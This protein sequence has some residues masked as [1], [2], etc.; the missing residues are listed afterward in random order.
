MELATLIPAVLCILVISRSGTTAAFRK[1]FLPVLLLMPTYFSWSMRPLPSINFLE[2]ATFPLGIAMFAMD[3]PRWKFT[4][5]DLWVAIWI[6]SCSY[7]DYQRGLTTNAIFQLFATLSSGLFPY[8]AGK[9]LIEQTGNRVKVCTMYVLLIS[10]SSFVSAYEFFLRRNPYNYIFSHFYPGQWAVWITQIRWG[11]GRVA[12]PFSQSELA[13]MMVFTALLFALW[14][15]RYNSVEKATYPRPQVLM[16]HGTRHIWILLAATY[17]TQARGPW[18]GGIMA[19]IFAGIGRAKFPLRRAILVVGT[20]VLIGLPLY[21][22][23]K[24][25]L[26]GP[27]KDYGSEKETAQYRAELFTNYIPVA[28]NGG[29]WGWGTHW[30]VIDGQNSIDNEYL[31]SWVTQG[32][33]GSLA[34]ILLLVESVLSLTIQAAKPQSMR[35]RHFVLT[36]IGLIVGIAFT[37]STVFLG[38]QSYYLLFLLIGWSQGIRQAPVGLNEPAASRLPVKREEDVTYGVRV[39]S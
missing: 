22:Y 19:I 34:L 38:D 35:E 33:V 23:G 28:E 5:T 32:W 12:G 16:K 37:I 6:L 10:F 9:L 7:A 39:Y 31:Y 20:I 17:M 24:D 30:P 3:L 15:G 21:T 26:A 1:V 4:R 2:A 11:F 27:R 25:Y 14:L 8:M 36:L 29:P 13:G 18:I